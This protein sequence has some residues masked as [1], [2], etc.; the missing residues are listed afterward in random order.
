[1]PAFQLETIDPIVRN[2]NR[3]DPLA[4]A[5]E[6]ARTEAYSKGFTEGVAVAT[7]GLEAERS[8]LLA[9][10]AETVSDQRFDLERANA[11][12]QASMVGLVQTLADVVSAGLADAH[13]EELVL[14]RVREIIADAQAG[15]LVVAV[16]PD[17]LDDLT[18]LVGDHAPNLAIEA[19][20][21]LTKNSADLRWAN[22]ADRIDLDRAA[23]DVTQA[24]AAYCEQ[25][26][27]AA[28]ER[29]KRTG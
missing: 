3:A 16:S 2:S 18:T 6:A 8:A 28:N 25:Q 7:Q 14:A 17:R 19:A 23:D 11:T 13:F 9:S 10:V 29:R 12:I 26:K 20:S 21:H 22:G 5:V 27:G 1:M 15:T 4:E 24:I